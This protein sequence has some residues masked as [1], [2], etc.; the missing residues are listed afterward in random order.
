MQKKKLHSILKS[1]FSLLFDVFVNGTIIHAFSIRANNSAIEF[2]ENSP[3][4][5]TAVPG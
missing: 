5:A 4:T 1:L 2:G 3:I